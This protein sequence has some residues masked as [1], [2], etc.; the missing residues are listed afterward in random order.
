MLINL[1]LKL[2]EMHKSVKR[3]DMTSKSEVLRYRKARV[4]VKQVS[5]DGKHKLADTW[6]KVPSVVV[7]QANSEIPVCTAIRE[8]GEG[9]T[10]ILHLST[11]ST[12]DSSVDSSVESSEVDGLQLLVLTSVVSFAVLELVLVFLV[13]FPVL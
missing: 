8:D 6:E 5:F 1:L 7:D 2:P 4:L 13:E 10:R 9:R 3:K 11:Y 12:S